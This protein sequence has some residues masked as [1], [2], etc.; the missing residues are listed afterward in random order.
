MS[1]SFDSSAFALVPF[2]RLKSGFFTGYLSAPFQQYRH[3]NVGSCFTS[4]EEIKLTPYTSEPEKYFLLKALCSPTEQQPRAAVDLVARALREKGSSSDI[5][6]AAGLILAQVQATE[7]A[8]KRFDEALWFDD[9]SEFQ[10]KDFFQD[11]GFY[12]Y[13]VGNLGPARTALE[14][15]QLLGNKNIEVS[16]ILADLIIGSND[17]RLSITK[18]RELVKLQ[19]GARANDTL[20]RALMVLADPLYHRRDIDEAAALAARFDDAT[21]KKADSSVAAAKAFM[22]REDPE[23]ALKIVAIGLAASPTDARLIALD[24]QLKNPEGLPTATAVQPQ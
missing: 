10:K 2:E 16:F 24:Q 19:P 20:M 14:Q 4:L 5:L 11:V 23:R 15:A 21:F 7:D 13:Q 1:L 17:R 22:Y 3:G 18:A 6:Y 9:F 8:L 12:N